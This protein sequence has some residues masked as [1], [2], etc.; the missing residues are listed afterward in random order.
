M[1]KKPFLLILKLYKKIISPLLGNH[2]RFYPTCSHYTYEAIDRHGVVKGF[3][4]G[5][6]R[7]L[8]CHPLHP[9]GMDPVPE[10]FEVSLRWIQKN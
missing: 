4:L 10:K 6:K 9:G 1:I 2:C 5:L 7:L 8:K 3:F